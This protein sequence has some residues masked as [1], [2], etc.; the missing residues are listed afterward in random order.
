MAVKVLPP[1]LQFGVPD[2]VP[3][4]PGHL[5]IA[6]PKEFLKARSEDGREWFVLD[7]GDKWELWECTYAGRKTR[8]NP[9]GEQALSK[10]P[11]F[12]PKATL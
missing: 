1:K 12:V 8:L 5:V 4:I 10:T 11:V 9:R 2:P 6:Q 7:A 3:A